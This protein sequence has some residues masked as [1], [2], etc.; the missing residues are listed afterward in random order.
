MR[1]EDKAREKI[2]E[3]KQEEA[4]MI[5]NDFNFNDHVG[6]LCEEILEDK[7]TIGCWI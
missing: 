5:T 6:I 2:I 1:K 4:M 3:E 7:G